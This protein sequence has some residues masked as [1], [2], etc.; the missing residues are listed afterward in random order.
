MT[1]EELESFAVDVLIEEC[2]KCG[3]NI[4][5]MHSDIDLSY[6]RGD[7]IINVKVLY[8]QDF[9]K[10]IDNFE[11]SELINRFYEAGEI[12]H[13][14]LAS[15]FCNA[16]PTGVPVVCGASC[17][18]KFYPISLIPDEKNYILPFEYDT[19]G[20]A[21]IYAKAWNALDASI[22]EPYLDKNFRYASDVVFEV[23]PSRYEYI[24]YLTGKFQTISESKTSIEAQ[25]LIFKGTNDI[26]VH[27]HQDNN[28]D[29]EDGAI[30]IQ[31]FQGRIYSARMVILLSDQDKR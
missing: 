19:L 21:K 24:D 7:L 27:I 15:A 9:N 25:P 8:Q 30:L 13:L 29:G 20:L 4:K 10:N 16:N 12:P 11:V 1:Q 22:I 31:T 26:G 5:R 17:C 6:T 23:I 28:P 18:F 2:Q 14:M 3:M